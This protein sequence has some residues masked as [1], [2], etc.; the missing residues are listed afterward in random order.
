MTTQISVDD[1]CTK[2]TVQ[3]VSPN[4]NCLFE[5]IAVQDTRFTATELRTQL[6][7]FYD[8]FPFHLSE[9]DDD[10]L[11]AK[12]R[13]AYITDNTEYHVITGKKN[14]RTHIER[15]RNNYEWAGIMD[16]IALSIILDRPIHLYYAINDDT[17]HVQEYVDHSVR[18][19]KAI[20]VTFN[21]VNHYDAVV[22]K[23]QCIVQK[24]RGRPKKSVPCK[25]R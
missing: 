9:N 6:G 15:I 4:G 7:K 23:E 5:S 19:Q 12:L 20:R 1:F 21:G 14:K 10:T 25:K 2:Y 18:Y 24:R 22:A 8:T 3:T 13:L 11:Q 17:F 16:I